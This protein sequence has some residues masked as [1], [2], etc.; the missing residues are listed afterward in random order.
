MRIDGL[1]PFRRR[2]AGSKSRQACNN[3]R[4]S[5]ARRP[6]MRSGPRCCR[7]CENPTR[8]EYHEH[9]ARFNQGLFEGCSPAGSNGADTATVHS[10]RNVGETA[11][12][13]QSRITFRRLSC[14]DESA[15]AVVLTGGQLFG[16]PVPTPQYLPCS[17]ETNRVATQRKSREKQLDKPEANKLGEV[18]C[19]HERTR[20]QAVCVADEDPAGQ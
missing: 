7:S 4:P 9:E 10:R 11:L 5:T 15:S 8:R 20:P 14:S 18:V 6:G 2:F 1:Y 19:T 12:C 16:K 13:A 3:S 17:K